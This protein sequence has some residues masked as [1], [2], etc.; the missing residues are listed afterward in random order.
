MTK[1]YSRV[2]PFARGLGWLSCWL[3]L[4][5]QE[6]YVGHTTYLGTDETHYEAGWFCRRC[7]L[8]GLGER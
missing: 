8:D 5:V 7:G 6:F 3:G 1:R 2:G 4:H